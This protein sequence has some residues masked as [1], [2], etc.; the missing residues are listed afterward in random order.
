MILPVARDILRGRRTRANGGSYR[1][2][3]EEVLYICMVDILVRGNTIHD[4]STGLVVCVLKTFVKRIIPTQHCHGPT[5]ADRMDQ[6]NAVWM[7]RGLVAEK[8]K[9][10]QRTHDSTTS[11]CIRAALSALTAS[12]QPRL[13]LIPNSKFH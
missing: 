3:P 13:L 10:V 8:C 12:E 4:I 7:L 11:V 6:R 9:T 5:N 2:C 1:M